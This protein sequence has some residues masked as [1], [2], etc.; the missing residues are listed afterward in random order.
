MSN[1]QKEIFITTT[2]KKKTFNKQQSKSPFDFNEIINNSSKENHENENKSVK[3]YKG[4]SIL[5]DNTKFEVL[6]YLIENEPK[7]SDIERISEELELSKVYKFNIFN[8]QQVI[9]NKKKERLTEINKQIHN[10]IINRPIYLDHEEKIKEMNMMIN[11]LK[12]K[13]EIAEDDYYKLSYVS[14][15][16][17]RRND[18]LK[19]RKNQ[20]SEEVEKI[21]VKLR[22]LK[23]AKGKFKFNLKNEID[24]LNKYIIFDTALKDKFNEDDKKRQR[25]LNDIA[26]EFKTAKQKIVNKKQILSKI[27]NNQTIIKGI[28]KKEEEYQESMMITINRMSKFINK[29]T[30][31][32][33]KI[34]SNFDETKPKEYIMSNFNIIL[35]DYVNTVKYFQNNKN[36]Y[37]NKNQEISKLKDELRKAKEITEDLEIKLVG[38]EKQK[39]NMLIYNN[40]NNIYK[41]KDDVNMESNIKQT[42]NLNMQTTDSQNIYLKHDNDFLTE[43]KNRMISNKVEKNYLIDKLKEKEL[44][45]LRL[46]EFLNTL[47]IKAGFNSINQLTPKKLYTNGSVV[48]NMLNL[49]ISMQE[50]SRQ[51]QVYINN[52]LNGNTN[53]NIYESSIN[54][55]S[56]KKSKRNSIIISPKKRRV[57]ENDIISDIPDYPITDENQNHIGLIS[58]TYMRELLGFELLSYENEKEEY[59]IYIIKIIHKKF[60][61]PLMKF[62]KYNLQFGELKQVKKNYVKE[63][64]NEIF[65]LSPNKNER[66]RQFRHFGTNVVPS[67]KKI[68][69]GMG[70]KDFN[71]KKNKD[72]DFEKGMFLGINKN[73]QNNERDLEN[74]ENYDKGNNKSNIDCHIKE[75]K[76]SSPSPVSY[77]NRKMSNERNSYMNL[78]KSMSM[79]NK[80]KSKRLIEEEENIYIDNVNLNI[81]F[82]GNVVKYLSKFIM[83]SNGSNNIMTHNKKERIIN[84]PYKNNRLILNSNIS[85]MMKY[86]NMRKSSEIYQYDSDNDNNLS[87]DSYIKSKINEIKGSSIDSQMNNDSQ[88]TKFTKTVLNM[89]QIEANKGMGFNSKGKESLEFDIFNFSKKNKV[90]FENSKKKNYKAL[91]LNSQKCVINKNNKT[92]DFKN[93]YMKNSINTRF[94]LFPQT[95]TLHNTR[96]GSNQKF[97]YNDKEN[98]ND[99]FKDYTNDCDK[100]KSNKTI[101][102]VYNQNSNVESIQSSRTKMPML[103][104]SKSNNNLVAITMINNEKKKYNDSTAS[105]SNNKPIQSYSIS[106]NNLKN[107]KKIDKLKINCIKDLIEFNKDDYSIDYLYSGSVFK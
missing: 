104:S 79:I 95:Q 43:L 67:N 26:D 96:K 97:N 76:F 32:M 56:I 52:K 57:K 45:L 106:I 98:F 93:K 11:D 69:I 51:K 1:Q 83:K 17:R 12:L 89:F 20:I 99:I 91:L 48:E 65:N 40:S 7:I 80:N 8:Q 36:L 15:E 28:I 5:K 41:N 46:F 22:N 72:E 66:R 18:F 14:S 100:V 103:Y 88:K 30:F 59:M 107:H 55:I 31:L 62:L 74:K 53:Y 49:P 50:G 90:L 64:E 78:N 58:I 38:K 81:K 63:K 33:I 84:S 34:F 44:Y 101:D 37:D 86:K 54:D 73:K 3:Y 39:L 60:L 47:I 82:K 9:I 29:N 23:I 105:K 102:V 4:K 85:S 77:K 16:E 35:D 70:N 68:G 24:L 10:E 13:V 2:T 27:I 75:S 94:N 6:N 42:E 19:Q 71:V 61:I 87:A 92:S 25:E 21:N